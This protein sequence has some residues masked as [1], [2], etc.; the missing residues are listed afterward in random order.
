M[1][2]VAMLNSAKPLVFDLTQHPDTSLNSV[3]F[4]PK[5]W[6]PTCGSSAIFMGVVGASDKNIQYSRF[7]I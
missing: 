4:D 5:Q 7:Y 2:V 6:F 1:Q 3:Q